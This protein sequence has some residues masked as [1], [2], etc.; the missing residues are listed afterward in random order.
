MEDQK[1]N[2]DEELN[3]TNDPKILEEA[4]KKYDHLSVCEVK[5]KDCNNNRW[6]ARLADID[7]NGQLKAVYS[8]SYNGQNDNI[9]LPVSDGPQVPGTVAVWG[10]KVKGTNRVET[11]FVPGISPIEVLFLEYSSVSVVNVRIQNGIPG[12]NIPGKNISDLTL[13]AAKTSYSQ[14]KGPLCR[15]DQ[16]WSRKKA[17]GGWVIGLNDSVAR[18]PQYRFSGSDSVRLSNNRCYL[19]HMFL[20]NPEGYVCTKSAAGEH[21]VVRNV[22]LSRSWEE[23][24]KES[25]EEE[26]RNR[27]VW[28]FLN[29]LD[30]PSVVKAIAEK[31]ECSLP[32]AQN[33]LDRFLNSAKEYR[34]ENSVEDR[35]LLTEIRSNAELQNLC[36]ELVRSDWEKE[37]RKEIEARKKDIT[38]L[39]EQIRNAEADYKQIRKQSGEL[40]LK[41]SSI[42]AEISENEKQAENAEKQN[43]REMEARK[44]ELANIAEDLENAESEYEQLRKRNEEL[45]LKN[46]SIQAEISENA[47]KQNQWRERIRSDWETENRRE[48]EAA[49]RELVDI[50]ENLEKA[51]TEYEQARKQNETL[52]LENSSIQAE[53]SE[54]EK[55]A[56]NAELQNRS[57]IEAGNRELADIRENLEKSKTEYEQIRRQNEELQSKNRSLQE[58]ISE[59]EQLAAGVENQVNERIRNAKENAAESIAD[60]AFSSPQRMSPENHPLVQDRNRNSGLESGVSRYQPGLD[61]NAAELENLE[62]WKQALNLIHDNLLDAGVANRY[63]EAL[64]AYLYASFLNRTPVLLAGPGSTEITEAF[65]LSLFGKRAGVLACEESYSQKTADECLNSG[66]E[67]VRIVNPFHYSWVSRLPDLVSHADPFFFAACPFMEDVQVEPKSLY[68]YFLPVVTELFVEEVPQA[69]SWGGRKSDRFQEYQYK[70]G[71]EDQYSCTVSGLHMN[72][73]IRNRIQRNLGCMHAMLDELDNQNQDYGDYDVLF[74]LAPYAEATM[75]MPAVL[76]AASE[77]GKLH[78]SQDLRKQLADLYGDQ[79]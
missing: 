49:N 13:F 50:R 60:R 29:G 20:G 48:I 12:K 70:G 65:S 41:N 67:I 9:L 69:I 73:L 53:I 28:E 47:E 11:G 61:L 22:L 37:N 35:I 34:E 24:Q 72:S 16:L 3:R 58:K 30:T 42:Q 71:K 33:M 44:K 7:G 25:K 8:N 63:A 68:N 2:R 14:Y 75:Q 10:W 18:L 17:E 59:N 62:D 26:E 36:R 66:D 23:F 21:E 19:N 64:A 57:E 74:A 39:E 78:V 27:Y 79:S 5:V 77:Q 55:Q 31:A 46:S 38:Q 51:K 54:Q 15:K 1:N 6:M 40:R 76:D 45:R 32:K 43:R 52:Q 56:E 4:F